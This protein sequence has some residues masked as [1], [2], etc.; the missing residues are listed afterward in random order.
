MKFSLPGETIGDGVAF[1]GASYA[2][3][4]KKSYKLLGSV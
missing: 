1:L 2:F 4:Y 3:A